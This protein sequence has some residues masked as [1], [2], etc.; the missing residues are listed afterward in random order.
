MPVKN[1]TPKETYL[2]DYKPA[3]Y[4]VD[5]IFLTFDLDPENTTA[6]SQLSLRRSQKEQD[7]HPLFLNGE[8]IELF[9]IKNNGTVLPK[10]TYKIEKEGLTIFEPPEVLNLEIKTGLKPSKNTR[11]SGLYE[12]GGILCTQNE[13]EGFRRITFF[14]DRPD[15]MT[16]FTTK[17]IASKDKYPILLSNGNLIEESDLPNGKHYAVWEDPFLKPCYLYALVAGNLGLI[18]STFKTQSN[19]TI[20]LRIYCDKGSEDKCQHAMNSLKKA[21]RWD[22]EKF[23]REYDLDLFMIVAV[24]AFNFGAMENKGLNIFNSNAILVDPETATDDNFM[25]VEKVVAHEYFHN[26]T[27]NRITLRDWFQLTLKEGLTVYRDQEFTADMHYR[28]IARIEDVFYLRK[29]Q[30][31]EDA[32][33]T[34]HPIKPASYIQIDNFYTTTIYYKGAEVVRMIESLLGKEDFKKGMEKYFLDYDGKAITTEDFVKSFDKIGAADLKAFSKWYTQAGTPEI[35]LRFDYDDNEEEFIL[36]I[37]QIA[38]SSSKEKEPFLFPLAVGF[39][40]ISGK[41]LRAKIA[42]AREVGTTYILTVSKKRER[43]AFKNIPKTAVPSLNRGFSAPIKITAPY[44]KEDLLHIMEYDED[45]FTRW[46]ASQELYKRILFEMVKDLK[47]GRKPL[48]DLELYEAFNS[49]LTEENLESGY[50]ACLLTL[51]TESEMADAQE[52]I[53]FEA[54]HIARELLK[55]SLGLWF[56]EPMLKMYKALARKKEYVIDTESMGLR[57]LKST[58]LGYL[59]ASR[60][61]DAIRLCYEQFRTANNMT[62]QFSALTLL[63]N[64]FCPERKEVLD[65][66]YNQWK[67]NGLV[68]CKWFMAQSQSTLKDTQGLV[69]SLLNHPAYD[70]KIPNNVR[71]LLGTFIQNLPQ[72]HHKSGSGYRLIADQ[73]LKIDKFNPHVSSGLV[74]GFKLYSKVDPLR[75]AMM[76]KEMERIISDDNLSPNVYELVS[77]CLNSAPKS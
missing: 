70:D 12:T 35:S 76:Q 17:I 19:R 32:G 30:F 72:F 65:S 8:D 15:V 21:M 38:S 28:G 42:N 52:I 18:K 50:K 74:Q 69:E 57:K 61:P 9:S 6:T 73:I 49:I 27:G 23:G 25:R 22:E 37:D 2:K 1:S 36:E 54:N 43:F 62:D 47:D 31:P 13:A 40:D 39:I 67:G 77:K 24:S 64:S 58:L 55:E 46:D 68:L 59:M 60:K 29:N 44:E 33:P 16:K 41:P 14:P 26:W 71:A 4:T 11:L 56:F 34:S 63:Q 66:F 53:D 5:S 20:E 45:S 75:K 7:G 10:G 3:P 51:P 48:P